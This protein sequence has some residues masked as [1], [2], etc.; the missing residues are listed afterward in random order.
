MLVDHRA[1]Y[2][3]VAPFGFLVE[4][5]KI[6]YEDK[7]EKL[8]VPIAS[9]NLH[10]AFSKKSTFLKYLPIINNKLKQ[11]QHDGSMEKILKAAIKKAAGK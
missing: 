5:E 10:I 3:V 2:A 6:G 9:R 4:A 1:D 7:I 11:L 8:P